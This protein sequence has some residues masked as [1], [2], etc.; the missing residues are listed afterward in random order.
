MATSRWVWLRKIMLA[1]FGVLI[2]CAAFVFALHNV[3]WS[4]EKALL[5]GLD[6]RLVVLA[7]SVYAVSLFVRARRWQ[8]LLCTLRPQFYADIVSVTIVGFAAN[9]LLPARLGELFRVDYL[10]KCTGMDRMTT[11]GTVAV[12]RTLDGLTVLAFLGLGVM[13]VGSPRLQS[14]AAG[15]IVWPALLGGLMLF[16]GLTLAVG[17]SMHLHKRL[18]HLDWLALRLAARILAGITSLNQKVLLPVIAL[19]LV[20]WISEA[21]ALVLMLASFD[22]HLSIGELLILA[23]CAT[24]STL[25]PTAPGFLGSFQLVFG[26]LLQA[27]DHSRAVGIAVATAMQLG[28]YLPMTVLGIAIATGRWT[29]VLRGLRLN[30]GPNSQSVEVGQ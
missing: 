28:C 1:G 24:L 6:L 5:A 20:V 15:T 19:T 25:I 11:I 13:L 12:E 23:G 2:G 16:G 30:K 4:E 9:Y 17:V 3:S 29:G 26:L 22:V 27:F 14:S 7:T 21:I 18:A 8:L 10:K